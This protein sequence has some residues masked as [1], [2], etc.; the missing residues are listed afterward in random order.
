MAFCGKCGK[1]VQDGVT[2]CPECGAAIGAAAPVQVALNSD[3]QDA[4]NNKV[5]AILAYLSWLVLIPLFAAKNSKFARF[6]TNQGLILAIIEIAW[7]ILMAILTGIAT[8]SYSW[9]FLS[10]VGTISWIGSIAFLVF[11][12]LGIVNVTKLE[13]KELPLIGKFKILK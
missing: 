11:A 1:Q 3:Q 4:Q 12:I 5:M 8:A 6:H 9:G 10:I 2:F 13:M 7:W